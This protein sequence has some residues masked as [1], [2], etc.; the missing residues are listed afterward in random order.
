[1][2]SNYL[3]VLIFVIIALV[4]AVVVIGLGFF[5]GPRRPDDEKCFTRVV[6]RWNFPALAV[7]SAS[8]V[9]S[10]LPATDFSLAVTARTPLS[11]S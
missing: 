4:M 3:P 9:L 6:K 10:D 11:T 8:S 1:M 2:L 5:L 7:A